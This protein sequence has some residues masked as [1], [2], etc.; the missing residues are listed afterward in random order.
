MNPGDTAAE[1]VLLL[2]PVT[3][4]ALNEGRGM[5]PGDTV[6][7]QVQVKLNFVMS[8]STKAEA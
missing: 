4:Q 8:R 5:N 1:G 2:T 7:A 6:S 3:V